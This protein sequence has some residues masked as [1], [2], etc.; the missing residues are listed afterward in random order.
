MPSKKA[1]RKARERRLDDGYARP[2]PEAVDGFQLIEPYE[3]PPLLV[4][5]VATQTDPPPPPPPPKAAEVA[6]LQPGCAIC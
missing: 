3:P 5:D 1:R 2:L 6:K 4:H